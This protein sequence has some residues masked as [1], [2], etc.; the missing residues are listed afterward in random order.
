MT[1]RISKKKGGDKTR[2]NNLLSS[3]FIQTSESLPLF[4]W[5]Y[6]Q[7]VGVPSVI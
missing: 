3:F 5:N 1:A 4:T 7:R 2:E 6:M